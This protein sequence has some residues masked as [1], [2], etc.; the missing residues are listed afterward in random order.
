MRALVDAAVDRIIEHIR[1]L[2]G[3]PASDVEDIPETLDRLRA[4]TPPTAPHRMTALLE[5]VFDVAVPKSYNA[6]GPGYMAYV[7]GG[8]IFPSAVADLIANSVNRYTGVWQPAPALLQLEA[9]VLRWFCTWMGLPAGSG[10]ILTT[11]GSIANQTAIV[12]ARRTRLPEDFLS[13]TLYA[14]DQ[15]HHSVAKAA[16]LAG[17]PADRIRS[18][19]SDDHYRIDLD[20]LAGMI[21]EDRE[22]GLAPFFLS[23]NAGTTN[24]GAVDDLTALAETAAEHGLWYHVD[25]A[26]GGFF[27]I[28]T[29][30]EKTLD[31]IQ[32]AD[33]ITLDPH[34]GLGLPFGTGALV[35][36]RMDDLRRAHAVSADYLPATAEDPDHLD[37]ATCSPE[38]SRDYRGLR[39]WLPLMLHGTG[40]FIDNLDE[41]LDLA[42]WAVDEVAKIPGVRIV[43]HPDLSIFAFRLEPD[44][45]TDGKALDTLNERWL[46]AT[47]DRKRVFLSGTRL[48]G[49]FTL[50][51]CILNF[52]T[53]KDRVATCI[54][55][56]AA[57]AEEVLADHGTK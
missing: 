41:K 7:P 46:Q 26:Y 33:S 53:H 25:A 55:D 50:R 38:L 3:Q 27:R 56:L 8:G 11:G 28:T 45:V 21:D 16:V 9:N 4:P 43:A 42:A 15:T 52:R 20:A 1:T 39:V 10:G 47:N 14:S 22:T 19:P 6:A 23:G 34:K 49:R 44:G 18:V 2:P 5:T 32:H 24:T 37:Y 30:G 29:R 12:T 35:V 36:R 54:E 51:V 31:G 13:G 48:D 40:P 17:F 57:A